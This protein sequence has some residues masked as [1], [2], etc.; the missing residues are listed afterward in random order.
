MR[1]AQVDRV[2]CHLQTREQRSNAVDEYL[3]ADRIELQSTPPWWQPPFPV[4]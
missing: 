2:L 1:V 3:L 4:A